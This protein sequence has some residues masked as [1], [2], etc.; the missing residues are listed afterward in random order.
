MANPFTTVQMRKPSQNTFDLSHDLKY[1]MKMGTLTPVLLQEVLP[2]DVFNINTQTLVRFAP[3][4]SP[5]MHSIRVFTHY[6]FVPNRIVWD[7]WEAFISPDLSKDMPPAWPTL[8]FSNENTFEVG[9]LGDYFGLPT[10]VPV[11]TGTVS[12]IPFAGYN[13]IYNEYYRDQNLQVPLAESLEDGAVNGFANAHNVHDYGTLM[14]RAWQ[15]DYFTSA[16]PFAQKGPAVDLPVAGFNDVEVYAQRVPGQSFGGQ[17]MKQDGTNFADSYFVNAV[18]APTFGANLSVD[19]NPSGTA[20]DSPVYYDPAGSLLARTSDINQTSATINDLRVALRLQEWFEKAARGGSRYVEQL[21]V[22]WAVRSSDARLNRPEFLGG[23]INPVIISE[24]LQTSESA[25]TPQATMAG[26]G[27]SAGSGKRIR[28][29]AEEHGY[30]FGIQSILPTTAYQQGLPR[31]FSRKSWEDYAWPTFAHLGEQAI[32]NQELYYDRADAQNEETFGY[33]PRYSEYRYT[34]SRVAGDFK[35]SLSFWHMGRIFDNRPNLNA[36]FIASDPTKRI[37]AVQD[38]D[39]ASLWCHSYH[40]V[41][42]KRKLPRYGT[43]TL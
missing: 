9:S 16:L 41:Y 5:V 34:P 23:A 38:D 43:P 33:I 37:F 39:V 13:K 26:H 7:N 31:H 35:T 4:V 3:M 17:L 1:S 22:H 6:F 2:G 40:K 36:E 18:K 15:H 10:G 8:R 30:I 19:D 28:Y 27:L 21:M 29:Y 20:G 14:N 32:L 11:D 12:A 24:V 42:V 25:D